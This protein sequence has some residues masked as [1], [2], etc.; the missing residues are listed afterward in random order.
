MLR[1]SA[2]IGIKLGQGLRN[3]DVRDGRT[4]LGPHIGAAFR[5]GLWPEALLGSGEVP[6]VRAVLHLATYPLPVGLVGVVPLKQHLEPEA[7]RGVSDLFLTQNM[8]APVHV[9]AG[10]HGLE[11]LETHEVLLVKRAQAIHGDLEVTDVLFDLLGAHGGGE[12]A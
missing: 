11:L 8:D 3:G 12:L 2:K 10:D 6:L 5:G 1:Q 4:G 9:L 7:L